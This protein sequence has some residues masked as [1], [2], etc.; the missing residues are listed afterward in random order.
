MV[1]N[2]KPNLTSKL[3]RIGLIALAIE[4]V[5][6]IPLILVLFVGFQSGSSSGLVF[7]LAWIWNIAFFITVPFTIC[8]G[9][10]Y[11]VQ[12]IK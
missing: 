11:L 12:K 6:I 5:A 10:V 3:L 7:V 9:I 8:V 1:E 4:I 2:K